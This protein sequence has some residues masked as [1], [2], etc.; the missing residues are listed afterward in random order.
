M[1]FY[2]TRLDSV[3]R[4]CPCC[5]KAIAK[6]AKLMKASADQTPGNDMCL[7][8][9]LTVQSINSEL[10]Q[11]FSANRLTPYVILLFSPPNLQF[12][13]CSVFN[14]AMLLTLPDADKPQ[15]SPVT[16]R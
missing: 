3:A 13:H 5:L 8:I 11:H 7:Q 6:A 1:V 14:P 9:L 2:S 12:K 10:I 16:R 4:P 15:T